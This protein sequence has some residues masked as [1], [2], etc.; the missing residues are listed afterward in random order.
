MSWF[1]NDSEAPVSVPRKLLLAIY[2]SAAA[3]PEQQM[4]LRSFDIESQNTQGSF[5]REPVGSTS[6]CALKLNV[7]SSSPGYVKYILMEGCVR[8]I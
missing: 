4:S 5:P 8:M 7:S 6:A 1:S 2:G 3:I